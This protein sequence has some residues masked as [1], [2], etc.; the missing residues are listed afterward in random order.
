MIGY[1]SADVSAEGLSYTGSVST[2]A[3]G[4]YLLENASRIMVGGLVGEYANNTS[5]TNSA[6]TD[7]TVTGAIVD[8]TDAFAGGTRN[9]NNVLTQSGNTQTNVTVVIR[10]EIA[11]GFCLVAEGYEISNLN[12]FKYFRDAVNA[13]TMLS[14]QDGAARLRHRPQQ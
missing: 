7:S 12:G 13:G 1:L 5:L 10:A 9:V 11:D 4:E 8:G 3:T 14:G 6:V 2:N